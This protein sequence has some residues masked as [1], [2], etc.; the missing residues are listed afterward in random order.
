MP[1]AVGESNNAIRRAEAN[2]RRSKSVEQT[3]GKD[4]GMVW[5]PRLQVQRPG[6]HV[7]GERPLRLRLGR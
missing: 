6:S 4:H 3:Q 2:R 1:L 7:H 5:K